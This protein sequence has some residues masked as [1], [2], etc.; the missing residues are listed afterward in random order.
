VSPIEAH[1][2]D[3]KKPAALSFRD[4]RIQQLVNSFEPLYHE[5]CCL[6]GS[7]DG[8]LTGFI[9]HAP[10]EALLALGRSFLRIR[11]LPDGCSPL[12][13][14]GNPHN[15]LKARRLLLMWAAHKTESGGFQPYSRR[16]C[17]HNPAYGSI[18]L[19]DRVAEYA[20]S[21]WRASRCLDFSWGSVSRTAYD[22]L[23][24]SYRSHSGK[25]FEE[26]VREAVRQAVEAQFLPFEVSFRETSVQGINGKRSRIDVVVDT[27]SRLILIPCKSS[28][29]DSKSH[30]NLFL[31]DVRDSL[32]SIGVK[33]ADVLVVF[34]GEGWDD[35]AHDMEF[36]HVLIRQPYPLDDE[37][38]A[39]M[40]DDI[41][42]SGILDA[43]AIAA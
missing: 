26:G 21:V 3:K 23:E 10:D 20:A 4:I 15:N 31:R 37:L 40:R 18:P 28:Q 17:K 19:S 35:V 42:D 30:S 24:G 6:A 11:N 1:F 36:R 38:I 16:S 13:G 41:L 9:R 27:G 29:V 12:N 34:G 8:N 43:E 14:A 22:G 5:L 39:V 7:N 2:N 25:I 33:P 32:L